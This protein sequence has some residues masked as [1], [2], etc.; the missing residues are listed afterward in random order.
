FIMA[1]QVEQL[2]KEKKELQERLKNQE[3]KIDY[4]ERAKRLEEIPLIKTAY[5]EQRVHDMELWEQQEEERIT[6]LQLEREK[7]LEHKSRLSRMLEDRD[8]FEARLKAS[9]RTVYEDK[10]KQFQ[11][12]LAEERRNR[13]E[14]RKKQ[15]KEERR[16]TY[17]REKEEEEQRLREE[18]LLK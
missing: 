7:A 15:R 8:L 5:E 10:L 12:R 6:T 14:E 4:F 13:L 17:Y 16:V 2:E 11:E 9:R 18:Q 1:K 3:K